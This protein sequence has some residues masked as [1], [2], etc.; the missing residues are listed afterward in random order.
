MVVYIN[1]AELSA[2]EIHDCFFSKEKAAVSIFWRQ[3]PVYEGGILY[4]KTTVFPLGAAFA[5]FGRNPA[6][7]SSRT[8]SFT[9]FVI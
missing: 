9:A 2:A 4:Y 7:C 1:V 6:C 5:G 8:L 3:P